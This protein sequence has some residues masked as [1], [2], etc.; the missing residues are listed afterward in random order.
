MTGPRPSRRL[1]LESHLNEQVLED[2]R[3]LLDSGEHITRVAT[4]LGLNVEALEKKMERKS[5]EHE[6]PDKIPATSTRPRQQP[7]RSVRRKGD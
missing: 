7:L 4:R 3:F 5:S 2:A 6:D 1:L